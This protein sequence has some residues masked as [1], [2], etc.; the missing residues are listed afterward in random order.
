M[1]IGKNISNIRAHAPLNGGD[2]DFWLSRR[3]PLL[4]ALKQV[5]Y[6]CDPAGSEM[7][8]WGD[9]EGLL[10]RPVSE[11]GN[12]CEWMRW[13]HP[14]DVLRFGELE[15]DLVEGK[16]HTLEYRFCHKDGSVIYLR[17]T[18]CYL[19]DEKTGRLFLTGSLQDISEMRQLS[20][21][22]RHIQKMKVFGELTGGIAHDFNNLLTIFQGYTEILQAE[23]AQGDHRADYLKEMEAAVERAKALTS[24]LLAFSRKKKDA[25]RPI[26][27]GNVLLDFSKMLRRIIRENIELVINIEEYPGWVMADPRQIEIIL[28]NL[29][30]NACE[31]MPRGGRLSI[32]VTKSGKYDQIIVSDNGVG[33]EESVLRSLLKPGS[34][35]KPQEPMENLGLPTCFA[36]VEQ[37]GGKLAAESTPGKGSTFRVSLTRIEFSPQ[38]SRVGAT[39]PEVACAGKGEKILI[40]EDDTPLQTTVAALT[41]EMGY[42]VFCAANG[43]EALRILERES[44]IRLVICDLVMP[45]MGGIELTEVIRRQWPEVRILLTSGYS[46][47]PPPTTASTFNHTAFLPKPLSR[48]VL[49]GKLRELLDV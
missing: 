15:T 48:G 32:E 27:L 3:E 23:F 1:L 12:R 25:P 19:R 44:E 46:S 28:I 39:P 35:Q 17:D 37:I 18:S 14:D 24:Q 33:M 40:V 21:D 49:A 38:E 43:Q 26:R 22:F 45:L 2:E 16:F 30:V 9:V 7:V 13:I 20:T 11:L 5:I 31:A 41:R 34:S 8:F 6:E 47:E 10:G 29:V 36:I 4:C 42:Q